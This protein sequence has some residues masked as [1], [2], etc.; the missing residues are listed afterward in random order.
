MKQLRLFTAPVLSVRE[1]VRGRLR[2]LPMRQR[3]REERRRQ[4]AP[5]FLDE[6]QIPDRPDVF[7]AVAS[8]RVEVRQRGLLVPY[9]RPARPFLAV[10]YWRHGKRLSNEEG[11]RITRAAM[12][13]DWTPPACEEGV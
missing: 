3:A 8:T 4:I 7:V 13:E 2:D 9:V 11:V 5:I 1:F 10:E 6:T 12:G